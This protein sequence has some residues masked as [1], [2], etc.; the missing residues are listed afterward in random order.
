MPNNYTLFS[1]MLQNLSAV[2][3]HWLSTALNWRGTAVALYKFLN[4]DQLSEKVS[5]EELAGWPDFEHTFECFSKSRASPRSLV[6]YSEEAG[7]I[8]HAAFLIYG[9]LRQFDSNELIQLSAAFTC[10]SPR[11]DEFGGVTC[12]IT[13]NGIIWDNPIH[14]A[15]YGALLSPG[16]K[17]VTVRR[18]GLVITIRKEKKNGRTVRKHRKRYGDRRNRKGTVHHR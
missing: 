8:E 17:A 15:I 3:T 4:L 16:S 10:S 14:T 18:G 7:N 9:L 2:K 1:A 5:A 13:K 6:V 12:W 11:P